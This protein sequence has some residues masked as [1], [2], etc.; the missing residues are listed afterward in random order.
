MRRLMLLRHAK[1]SWDQDGLDDAARPLAARGRQAAP[2]IGRYIS[3]EGLRP[4]LVLCSTAVRARQTWDL[5][6]AEWDSAETGTAPRLEMRPSLYLAVPGDIV[7]MLRRL[8]DDVGTAMVIGHNPG[9]A[10]L[11]SMLAARGDPHGL[12]TMI[13]KFPTAALAVIT[14]DIEPWNAVAPGNG[15]LQS[16]VR[17]KDLM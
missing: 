10:T 1:S 15:Y 4:D 3:R 9:M 17:P 7:S 6:T 14:F 8:D 11:G 13:A 5:V 16:F 12:K 2:L